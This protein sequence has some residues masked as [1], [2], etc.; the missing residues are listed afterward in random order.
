MKTQLC[1]LFTDN[2][3]WIKE[4]MEDNQLAQ[5]GWCLQSVN[6]LL[7]CVGAA[8]NG[9]STFVTGDVIFVQVI[10]TII[11][12]RN[13]SY[14]SVFWLL[15]TFCFRWMSNGRFVSGVLRPALMVSST[16]KVKKGSHSLTRSFLVEQLLEDHCVRMDFWWKYQINGTCHGLFH[17][18]ACD[19]GNT[20][21]WLPHPGR[22]DPSFG[23]RAVL[24]GCFSVCF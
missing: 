16:G 13:T 1:L 22:H 2:V 15:R 7:I 17:T 5:E 9:V 11:H 12:L 23:A 24:W 18:Q 8:I 19:V 4:H 20:E 14:F 10:G 21:G 3:L 6:S